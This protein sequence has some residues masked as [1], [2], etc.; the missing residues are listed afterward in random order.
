MKNVIILKGASG[1]GK[2]TVAELFPD[3]FICCADDYHYNDNDEYV[4]DV[5][6]I[7]KA[8]AY[9]RDRFD[10]AIQEEKENIV[11]AN[12]NT[13]PKE[14]EYYETKGKDYGYRIF[15]LVIEKRHDNDNDHQTPEHIRN[16]Q[17]NRLKQNIKLL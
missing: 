8:H 2:S 1:A 16:R 7:K 11:I 10:M 17:A 14:W 9:C 4:F 6:N 3:P 5:N 13:S 15:H 12:T